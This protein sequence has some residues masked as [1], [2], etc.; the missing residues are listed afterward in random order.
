MEI[1]ASVPS[2]MEKRVEPLYRQEQPDCPDLT[3]A[4]RRSPK[5][6]GNS[7]TTSHQSCTGVGIGEPHLL[8]PKRRA[9]PS[10]PSPLVWPPLS[11]TGHGP[12]KGGQLP[13]RV[14]PHMTVSQGEGD[15]QQGMLYQHCIA[16]PG[17]ESS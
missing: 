10:K 6:R 17:L 3:N 15:P 9:I 4:S 7:T 16:E 8:L 12:E 5:R 2:G 14:S 11:Y 13:N 1:A